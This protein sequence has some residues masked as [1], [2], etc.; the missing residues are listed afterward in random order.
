[1]KIGHPLIIISG[2]LL[3]P[4]IHLDAQDEPFPVL[5]GKYFGQ[6]PPGDKAVIFAKDIISTSVYEH[7]APAF[8][9]DGKTVLWT[10]VEMGKPAR[11]ME[12]VMIGNTWGKPHTPS[13]ADSSHD[14]FYPF[15]SPD[16]R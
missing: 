3:S 15:F 1:M 16:G 12:M 6:I 10:I 11:L 2:I 13:F 8:S 14:D 5:H 7:S 9:P 4:F